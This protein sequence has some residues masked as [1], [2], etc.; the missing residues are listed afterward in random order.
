VFQTW[1]KQ[2]HLLI[3]GLFN[4]C[5]HIPSILW[6]STSYVTPMATSA[7]GPIM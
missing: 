3:V 4:V 6:V 1:L 5:A 7:W 2:P